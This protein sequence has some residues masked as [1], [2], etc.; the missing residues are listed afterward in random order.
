MYTNAHVPA[1]REFVSTAYVLGPLATWE[2]PSDHRAVIAEMVLRGRRAA[3]RIAPHISGSQVFHDA[4]A[5]EFLNFGSVEVRLD[6][7]S[8]QGIDA[9][10]YAGR[11]CRIAG[12][13]GRH[14]ARFGALAMGQVHAHC[15]IWR[16]SWRIWQ[17]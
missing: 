8:G 16:R 15:C 7:Q 2:S 12:A 14:V 11:L 5:R 6:A 4:F 10:V 9:E 13:G 17:R 3:P 1:F